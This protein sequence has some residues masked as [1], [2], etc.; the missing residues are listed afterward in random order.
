VAGHPPPPA[1][2][3]AR[4]TLATALALALLAT[5]PYLVRGVPAT[6][7]GI[8]DGSYIVNNPAVADGLTAAAVRWAFTTFHVANWHPLAWLSHLLDV[9]LFGLDARG[10]HATSILI[11][12]LN[13]AL[14]FLALLRLTGARWPSALAA[15]LFG[16]HPLHVESVAWVAERKDVLA[17]LF[18]MLVLLAWERHVRRGAHAPTLLAVA[19]LLALGL[20]AKPMLVTVPFVL[21]LLDLWPL[22]RLRLGSGRAV[23]GPSPAQVLVEKLPLLALVI[24]SSIMTVIAQRAAGAVATLQSIGPGLRAANAV[25]SGAE[26]LAKTFWP[27]GLAVYY[28]YPYAGIPWT[29]IAGALALLAALT[30]AAWRLARERPYLAVGWCWFLGMLVPVIGFVQVGKQA[31]ADRYTY[32]PLIGVFVA[33]AWLAASLVRLPRIGSAIPWLGAAAVAACLAA[34]AVQVGYWTDSESL[35]RRA[36]AVTRDNPLAHNNLGASLHEQG[37]REE[38]LQHFQ[39]ALRIRPD[40]VDA[41]M[42]AGVVLL[43]LGRDAEAADMFRQSIRLV[44]RVPTARYYLGQ[45]LSAQ[46][47]HRDAEASFREALRLRT[48]YAEA[49]AYLGLSLAAQGRLAEADAS[50][51]AAVHL[52][53][54]LAEASYRLGVADAARGRDEAALREFSIALRMGLEPAAAAQANLGVGTALIRLDRKPEAAAPLERALALDPGNETA[55][56]NLG[57]LRLLA[58]RNQEALELF[59][60]VLA[61]APDNADARGFLAVTLV[62]LGRAADAVREY[63]TL[64]RSRPQDHEL[65]YNLGLALQLAGREAEALAAF[66]E[67]LRLHPGFAPAAAALAGR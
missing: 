54:D 24:A 44:P 15:A 6:F 66:R 48:D 30:A 43:D 53:P 63:E 33:G 5:L 1:S 61:R 55:A 45:A 26:Y 49:A 52:R 67:A 57:A 28:P 60:A 10:H 23:R 32:L 18:F 41:L 29:T 3:S 42:N 9:T 34:S 16:V 38:A 35:F 21:L 46:G 39:Q 51:R 31:M 8:D 56:Y 65:L 12:G 14:L 17:G 40:Y 20:M 7:V 62:Q 19:A 37:R 50:F 58:G 25:V 13:T 4:A 64:L 47:L 59:T 22:G 27:A 36:I 11:H 2:A